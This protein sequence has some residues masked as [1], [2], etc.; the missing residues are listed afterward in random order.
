[1]AGWVPCRA[2]FFRLGAAK[3]DGASLTTGY[4]VLPSTGLRGTSSSVALSAMNSNWLRRGLSPRAAVARR[5]EPS[6]C[7]KRA[8]LVSAR[9]IASRSEEHTSELQSLRH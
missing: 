4:R 5:Y 6:A 7:R 2:Y 3:G 1:M 8:L 9:E